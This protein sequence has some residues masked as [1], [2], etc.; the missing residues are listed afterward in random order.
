MSNARDDEASNIFIMGSNGRGLRRLTKSWGIDASPSFSPDGKKLAFVSQRR[1]NPQLFMMNVDGS[2][3]RRLTYFGDYNQEPRWSPG[4]RSI[5]FTAR[6]EYLKY[7]LFLLHLNKDGSL[8][9]GEGMNPQRLTQNQGSN[10]G[11]CWSPDGLMIMFVSNRFGERKLF[12]MSPDG[13]YQR[14]MIR[15]RGDYETPAWSPPVL[16]GRRKA[17]E[18]NKR[19]VRRV[20]KKVPRKNRGRKTGSTQKK[21]KAR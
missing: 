13:K 4:G 19:R 21:T 18:V 12:L 14:L 3:Q 6:D 10:Y 7:D 11:G 2:N 9:K 5:L 15:T 17:A 20:R 16:S 1:V 8:V